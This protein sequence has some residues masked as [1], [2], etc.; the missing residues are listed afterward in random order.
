MGSPLVLE[1]DGG[2]LFLEL[3][4]P[5]GWSYFY[6]EDTV[7]R[8]FL[9]ADSTEHILSRLLGVLGEED[10]LAPVT[11]QY[12]GY[13]VRCLLI[14]SEVHYVLYV[15]NQNGERLLF[16]QNSDDASLPIAGTVRLSAEQ[17]H[18][19][20]AQIKE[21]SPDSWPSFQSSSY[22]DWKPETMQERTLP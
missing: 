12:N 11:G 9:G 15:A 7:Q 13:G 1:G 6:L 19:W 10:E 20:L 3:V 16:W 14:L 2:T 5:N 17:R 18:Q 22:L 8:I 21:V 4:D